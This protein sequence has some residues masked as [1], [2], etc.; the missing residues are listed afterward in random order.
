MKK[1]I[2]TLLLAVLIAQSYGQKVLGGLTV[3]PVLSW[4]KPTIS[5]NVEFDKVRMGINFGILGDF[6]LSNNFAFSTAITI[7]NYGGRVSYSDSIPEFEVSLGTTDSIYSLP[8]NTN[9]A[10]KLQFIE[11][12]IALKLKTNEIGAM[13]YFLKLVLTRALNGEPKEMLMLKEYPI[14]AYKK[15]LPF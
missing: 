13:T 11:I 2:F 12:P 5:E 15:K 3:S 1:Y 14:K 9:I 8:A 7:N 6:H 4:M 10:Y